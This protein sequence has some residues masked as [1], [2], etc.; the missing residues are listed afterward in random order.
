MLICGFSVILVI[1]GLLA[2]VVNYRLLLN[3]IFWVFSGWLYRWLLILMVVNIVMLMLWIIL[4]SC[5]MCCW[6]LCFG[7]GG[8]L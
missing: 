1:F 5:W 3:L 4:V 7:M 8:F 6:W 2:V